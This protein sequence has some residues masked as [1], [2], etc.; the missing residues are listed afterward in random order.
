MDR[1]PSRLAR[2]GA[3]KA[4]KPG[5]LEPQA[6]FSERTLRPLAKRLSGG[7][8]RVTSSSFTERTEK[9]L[10]LSGN[11]GELRV[12][13]WLGLKAIGA[14]IGPI[15]FF[16]LFAVFGVLCFPFLIVVLLSG[17]GALFGYPAPEFWLGGRVKKRQKA[18][19]LNI[20]DALDLL[21]IS[22]R[23]GLGFDAALGTVVETLPGPF[24]DEFRRERAAVRVGQQRRGHGNALVQ[25]GNGGLHQRLTMKQLLH[26]VVVQHVIDGQQAHALVVHHERP[27]D[28]TAMLAGALVGKRLLSGG[29]GALILGLISKT[30]PCKVY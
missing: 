7:M 11:P 20:P 12:A 9:R 1:V 30:F 22:F 25:Q 23:A 16:F 17:V 24:S 15:L 8:S 21:T 14:I 28:S 4:K 10:A 26:D 27:H 3:R 6:P 2:R 5:G 18:I 29:S 13:D 19:L